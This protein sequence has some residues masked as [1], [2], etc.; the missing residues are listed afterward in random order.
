MMKAILLL[1]LSILGL[2]FV[3]AADYKAEGKMGEGAFGSQI[4]SLAVQG[5]SLYALENDGTVHRFN[6]QSGALEQTFESGQD[7]THA[8][9]LD[10]KGQ[11][12]VF[13]TKTETKEVTRGKRKRTVRVPVG[14][15]CQLFDQGGKALRTL[16]LEGVKSVKAA[17]FVGGKLVVADLQ[18]RALFFIDPATGKPTA[19]VKSGLRICCGIFDFC[20]GPDN[21][22]AVSNLG[23]FKLQQYDLDGKLVKE[24]GKRGKGVSDFHGCCNPVSAGYLANGGI[25]TVEKSPTRIKIYDAD[26][27]NATLVEGVEELVKGCSH[28]P[29]AIDAKGNVFLAAGRKGY[30]VKCVPKS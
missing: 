29:V 25:V 5:E 6:T 7:N 26:G 21:T 2:P 19:S 27:A 1:T 22:V 28:I 18:Q 30:L 14:V 9:A 13:A 3:A 15:T 10:A 11:I 20:A 24:F 8:L 12:H 4:R 17:A 16:S 23:A